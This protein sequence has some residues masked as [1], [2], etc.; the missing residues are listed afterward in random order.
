MATKNGSKFV[1]DYP[2][3]Y[4]KNG[5]VY[6]GN[7][8]RIGYETGDGDYRINHDKSNDGTLYKNHK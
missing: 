6:N 3:G 2:N 5:T 7:G 8:E 4:V 1:E